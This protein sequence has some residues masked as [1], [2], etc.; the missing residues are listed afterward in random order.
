[1]EQHITLNITAKNNY[2]EVI[3]E[4]FPQCFDRFGNFDIEKFKKNYNH[5][6]SIFQKK[7]MA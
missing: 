4:H 7:A 1:M 6:K 2:L 3:K 5:K